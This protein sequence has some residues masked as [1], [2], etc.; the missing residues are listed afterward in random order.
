MVSC[1]RLTIDATWTT[2]R[3]PISDDVSRPLPIKR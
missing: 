1:I 2:R 3:L